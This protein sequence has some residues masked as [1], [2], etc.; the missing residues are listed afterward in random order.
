MQ[1]L[2]DAELAWSER[3]G[4]LREGSGA[5]VAAFLDGDLARSAAQL[6]RVVTLIG[7]LN[8]PVEG[9]ANIWLRAILDD[10]A[11]DIASTAAGPLRDTALVGAFRKGKQAERVSYE[12]AL[13]LAGRI[14]VDTAALRTCRDEEAAADAALAE[15]LAATVGDLA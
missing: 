4:E 6:E 14:G 13:A 12:T 5:R 15:L 7:A 1:D 8:A 10:A 9:D 2:A 11:R 3:G